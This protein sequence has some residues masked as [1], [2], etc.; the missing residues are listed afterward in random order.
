MSQE[1]A[2]SAQTTS[3]FSEGLFST[4][5]E[6]ADFLN[7][8]GANGRTFRDFTELTP[9]S[10]E[11]FYMVAFNHYNSGKY[12]DAANVFRLLC[13]LDH[14]ETKYWKGLAASRENMKDY[15]GALQAYGY[16][17]LMDVRDPYPSFHGSK[18]LL[19]LGRTEDAESA[20][21]AA[22]FNSQEKAEFADMHQQAVDLIEVIEKGKKSIN[23]TAQ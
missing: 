11:V 13:T 12:E 4:K 14:F 21:R 17:T 5:E 8:F 6:L 3:S 2:E 16:L 1:T 10:M 9:E 19:A 23:E 20:L 22:I 15:E 7:K 18:C